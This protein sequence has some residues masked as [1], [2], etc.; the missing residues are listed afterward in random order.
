MFGLRDND[1]PLGE[2][3]R[4]LQPLMTYGFQ[5]QEAVHP[6]YFTQGN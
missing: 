1:A 4:P 6:S 2:R 5:I 3:Q